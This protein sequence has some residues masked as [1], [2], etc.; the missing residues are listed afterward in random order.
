[1]VTE[2][3]HKDVSGV[4]VMSLFLVWLLVTQVGSCF[5]ILLTLKI[6][7]Y[8]CIYVILQWQITFKNALLCRF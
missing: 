2:R 6:S 8:F 7:K 1:M 5:E 3:G 4:L